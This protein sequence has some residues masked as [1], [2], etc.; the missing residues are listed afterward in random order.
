MPGMLMRLN[1]GLTVVVTS[2]EVQSLFL[3]QRSWFCEGMAWVLHQG[4]PTPGS[5]TSTALW[6]VRNQAEQQ[7][8]SGW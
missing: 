1:L 6:P 5:G 4:A 2:A 8:V 7:E 3:C